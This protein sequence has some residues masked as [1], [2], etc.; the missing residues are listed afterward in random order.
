M[1]SRLVCLP[2]KMPEVCKKKNEKKRE[3][4]IFDLV[5]TWKQDRSCGVINHKTVFYECAILC[6]VACCTVHFILRKAI[7]WTSFILQRRS[8]GSQPLFLAL[9]CH[10]NYLCTE[11]E[12][13]PIDQRYREL[14]AQV[15]ARMYCIWAEICGWCDISLYA[16]SFKGVCIPKKKKT[17][18]IKHNPQPPTPILLI[19]FSNWAVPLRCQRS[20]F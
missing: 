8:G 19:H 9:L 17:G 12:D 2:N 6:G 18:F 4:C 15:S 13:L 11:C 16:F 20:V 5:S 1:G 10:H 7:Y 3:Q 14:S